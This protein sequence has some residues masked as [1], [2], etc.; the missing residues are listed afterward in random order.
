M[1]RAMRAF[2]FPIAAAV[3]TAG[4]AF[5]AGAA[6]G[7]WAEGARASVRLIAAGIGEDGTLDAGIEIVLPEGWHTYWRQPGDAGIAPIF[8]FSASR[9]VASADVSFP[10]PARL[11]DGFTVT[12]IYEGSV[13][14]PVRVVAT[15]PGSP[16]D[17]AVTIELGV[18][19]DICVPDTVTAALTIPPG[20]PDV[21]SSDTLAAARAAVPTEAEAGAFAV[22][23]AVRAGGTDKKPV[24]RISAVVPDPENAVLFVEAPDNWRAYAPVAVS[25]SGTEAVWDV[26]FSRRG[27]EGPVGSAELRLTITA[28]DRAI[29]QVVVTAD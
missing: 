3:L 17:L 14:L 23:S 8:D 13:V 16:V 25:A 29:E 4:F 22:T 7:A 28:G 2:A 1:V 9:N 18:C 11:D 20:G 6:E 15:D 27:V 12:N 26:K 21:R 24:F 19:D 5:P 10:A